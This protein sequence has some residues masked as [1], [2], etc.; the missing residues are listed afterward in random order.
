[1]AVTNIAFTLCSINY[2]A[3]AKTLFDSLKQTNPEWQFIIGLIDRNDKGI[4][5]RELE[6]TTVEVEHLEIPEFK[7]MSQQYTMVELLTS[8]KP[9]YFRV[10]TKQLS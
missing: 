7:R 9:F 1:M 10:V 6:C 2:L 3:Q 5:L 4:N 8:V